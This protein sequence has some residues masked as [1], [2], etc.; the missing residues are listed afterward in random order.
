M[1]SSVP[2]PQTRLV[3]S[4]KYRSRDGSIHIDVPVKPTWPNADAD[5]R[6]PHEEVGS[7]VSHPSARELP[8]TRLFVTARARRAGESGG[9][10]DASPRALRRTIRAK[11][12]TEAAVP[13]SPAWPAT[14]PSA[15][16]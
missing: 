1:S 5:I 8:G 15:A 10:I 13:N 16:A 9:G 7:I 3:S 14:P 2:P 11:A 4:T 12:P 6:V